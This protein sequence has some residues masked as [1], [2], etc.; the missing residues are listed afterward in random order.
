MDKWQELQELWKA[1]YLGSSD[2]YKMRLSVLNEKASTSNDVEFI[3]AVL[4]LN[5]EIKSADNKIKLAWVTSKVGNRFYP[6]ISVNE[7]TPIAWDESPIDLSP[8]QVIK[9]TQRTALQDSAFERDSMEQCRDIPDCSLIASLINIKQAALLLPSVKRVSQTLYHVNLSFNGVSNRL[10]TVDTSL[11][12]TTASGEQL[13]LRSNCL[14]DKVIELSY[15]QVLF[16]SYD[17][18]GSNV[19]I[20]T[21]RLTG[22]LPEVCSLDCYS[23]STISRYHNSGFCLIALGTGGKGSFVDKSL[24]TNHDYPLININEASKSFQLCDPLDSN[25]NL[26]LNYENV[27]RNFS[28]L[29]I[30]WGWTKLFRFHNKLNIYYSTGKCN[31]FDCVFDKP[32]LKVMNETKNKETVW[33]LL[34]SHVRCHADFKNVSYLNIISGDMFEE[35]YA[36]SDSALDIGLQLKKIDLLPN[37]HVNLFCHSSISNS[38]TVHTFSITSAV[39]TTKLSSFEAVKQI[40]VETDENIKNRRISSLDYYLNPTYSLEIK[41]DSNREVLLNLQ[42]LSN[43]SSDLL[44][45]QLFHLNDDDLSKPILFDNRYMK[46]KYN[47]LKVPVTTNQKYKVICSKYNEGSHGL[48]KLLAYVQDFPA[49]NIEVHEIYMEYGGLPYQTCKTVTFAPK[50]VR[51]K[52]YWKCQK[53]NSYFIRVKPLNGT[54]K[55]H[56]ISVRCNIFD[57]ETHNSLYNDEHFHTYGLTISNIEIGAKQSVGLLLEID[58]SK[59]DEI[60]FQIFIGSKWSINL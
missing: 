53:I 12:P 50:K 44:N 28:Q 10:V 22:F 19:A 27:L 37:E 17:A 60:S 23:F 3:Q 2:E 32:I 34:E 43:N 4:N 20:D 5:K 21:Y 59:D 52:I 30:N 40:S 24:R 8:E 11:I 1:F 49:E 33:L 48:C 42:L 55:Y 15:L 9:Y 51:A 54:P 36:P 29:Y 6:P 46:G 31:A 57:T 14:V 45:L 26:Q 35:S 16:G 58:E 25:L 7:A 47:K 39:R 41:H 13:S 18:R 56:N 38:F